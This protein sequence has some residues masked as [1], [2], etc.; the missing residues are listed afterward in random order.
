MNIHHSFS[1]IRLHQ[2]Y[3]LESILIQLSL[4][5]YVLTTFNLKWSK[6]EWE[7]YWNLAKEKGN[8]RFLHTPYKELPT[9]EWNQ[10]IIWQI[11]ILRKRL[12]KWCKHS[13]KQVWVWN[14]LKLKGKLSK[15][16]WRI[17]QDQVKDQDNILT[18]ERVM[19]LCYLNRKR[20][21]QIWMS[22]KV[23]KLQTLSKSLR[24]LLV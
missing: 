20:D 18:R 11:L 3:N 5:K 22:V 23:Y 16:P 6:V 13:Y 1:I 19:T 21:F 14:R 17:R 12:R 10:W 4:H 2:S 15:Q 24:M 9:L 8:F 7:I